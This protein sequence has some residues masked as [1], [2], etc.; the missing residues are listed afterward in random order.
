MKASLR[1]LV[2]SVIR[3]VAVLG[4]HVGVVLEVCVG[5]GSGGIVGWMSRY[6]GRVVDT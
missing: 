3:V 6:L 4:F 1:I 5:T 2:S